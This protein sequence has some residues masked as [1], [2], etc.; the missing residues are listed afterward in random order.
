MARF[1]PPELPAVRETHEVQI[2]GR[3]QALHTRYICSDPACPIH[4]IPSTRPGSLIKMM[5][6]MVLTC[7]AMSQTR[8]S[9]SSPNRSRPS[10]TSKLRASPSARP[11]SRVC[12]TMRSILPPFASTRRRATYW[13]RTPACCW[14]G[15][16][17]TRARA[18]GRHSC[19]WTYS[20][21][22]SSIRALP[23][24]WTTSAS[25]TS[26]RGSAISLT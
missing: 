18:G 19:S 12:S 14:G 22:G 26:S 21:G 1:Q 25:M 9:A 4:S 10:S 16:A 13:R 15:T 6:T 23:R 5:V 20:R 2:C 24:V 3:G 8:S 7:F 17:R 11:R